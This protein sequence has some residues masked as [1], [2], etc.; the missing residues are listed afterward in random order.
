M[1]DANPFIEMVVPRLIVVTFVMLAV[2]ATLA[3]PWKGSWNSTCAGG[4]VEGLVDE[5]PASD[6]KLYCSG[7]T[8]DR[9]TK[10]P[11]QVKRTCLTQISVKRMRDG[12]LEEIRNENTCTSCTDGYAFGLIYHKSR[13]GSCV[14]FEYAPKV[15]IGRL[16]S[17]ARGGPTH[18]NTVNTKVLL[19][20]H[21]LWH[22]SISN[23]TVAEAFDGTM[24]VFGGKKVA[25]VKCRVWKQVVCRGS[26]CSNKKEVECLEICKVVRVLNSC[27]TQNKKCKKK[28]KCKFQETSNIYKTQKTECN[29][30]KRDMIL[31]PFKNTDCDKSYCKDYGSIACHTAALLE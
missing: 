24:G 23:T 20:A 17:N 28:R 30:E 13:A 16:D 12:K 7:Q 5:S 11:N 19:S 29:P 21:M 27:D 22:A 9:V 10:C 3:V 4:L 26:I 25:M 14:T 2:Q 8:G 18:S 31:P 15:I 1:G 6:G